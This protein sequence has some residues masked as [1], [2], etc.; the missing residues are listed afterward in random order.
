M[1]NLITA[2]KEKITATKFKAMTYNVQ[3]FSGINGQADVQKKVIGNNNAV[4][5]GIQ[6][7]S[8]SR[9]IKPV[10][11]TALADYPYKYFSAHK[12]FLGLASKYALKSVRSL[13]FRNQDPQDMTQYGQTRAYMMADLE[14][15]GKVITIIN[16]HLAFLTQSIKWKQMRELFDV[17]RQ[18][19][20]VILMGDFNCFMGS[21]GDVEYINM[22]KMFVAAGF[23]LANCDGKITKTWTDKTN[24]KSLDEFTYPTDNII[25][26][27]NITI[28]KVYFDKKK[29]SSP[30]GCQ[31]DHIPI[32]A[33]VKVQ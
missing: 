3:C 17:A 21:P 6:E 9:T 26:S 16:A 25:V 29:L 8:T 13:D 18:H 12:A 11:Q 2:I 4:V 20:R 10:G 5:I 19:E 7:L 1:G 24:P 32:I 33:L 15:N 31:M 23:H 14:I 22:Y 27:P 30:N 28:K